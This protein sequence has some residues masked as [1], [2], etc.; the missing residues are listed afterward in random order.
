MA[1]GLENW[2]RILMS[3]VVLVLYIITFFLL[4][5]IKKRTRTRE[6]IK[7]S[8]ICLTIGIAILV[9]MG[10]LDVLNKVDIFVIPFLYEVLVVA[11]SVFLLLTIT[12]YLKS[13]KKLADEKI[14]KIN[15]FSSR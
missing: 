4:I 11:F 5:E 14:K 7:N 9:I 3:L 2:I 12:N 1:L 8:F 10:I 15:Y 6:R 13:L